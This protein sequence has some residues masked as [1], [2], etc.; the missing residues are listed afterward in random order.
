[1]LIRVYLNTCT[2]IYIFFF[3]FCLHIYI[4]IYIYKYIYIYMYMY[5]CIN[6]PGSRLG[7]APSPR[8]NG[9]GRAASL[10]RP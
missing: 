10:P 3:F 7:A 5:I 4:Y 9:P 2:C 8:V 1:M 6:P